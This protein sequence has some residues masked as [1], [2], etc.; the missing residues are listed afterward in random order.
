MTKEISRTTEV[1]KAGKYVAEY[2]T[3][4]EKEIY[5]ELALAMI[6]KKINNCSWIKSIKRTPLYNGTQKVTITFD[7]DC[8]NI[9]IVSD[10]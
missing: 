7:N 3:T 6:S 1:K 8:R 4:N 2:T 5:E 10:H 9:Y